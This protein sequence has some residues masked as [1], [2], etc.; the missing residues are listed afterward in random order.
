MHFALLISENKYDLSVTLRHIILYLSHTPGDAG[1]YAC[2]AL[3]SF[4]SLFHTII[5]S[6]VSLKRLSLYSAI[7]LL[8]GIFSSCSDNSNLTAPSAQNQA[9]ITAPLASVNLLALPH[10]QSAT[11]VE[12]I[13]SKSVTITP[14]TGGQVAVA[15]SYT[16]AN[17]SVVNISMDLNF[18]PGTVKETTTIS[19]S[20][21]N[22][23]LMADFSP[24]G[25]VFLKP[26]VL[27]AKIS[28]LDLSSV[29]GGADV[30]LFYINKFACEAMNA[31]ITVDQASGT[32]SMTSGQ[33]PHFSL[34]GF[35]FLK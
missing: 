9:V 3:N 5:I 7:A 23:T 18:A 31:A 24:S 8:V 14:E 10:R 12:A 21:D 33:I 20:L 6:E 15:S 30:K 32:I 34:Y 29:P 16:A 19:I 13:V 1:L 4:F 25:S 27:N 2:V 28:G 11:S 17:G 35:G 22:E 26:A